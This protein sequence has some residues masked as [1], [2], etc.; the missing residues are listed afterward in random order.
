[1]F[2]DYLV[3]HLGRLGYAIAITAIVGAVIFGAMY[4]MGRGNKGQVKVKKGGEQ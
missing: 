1:M 3:E 2:A 4:L